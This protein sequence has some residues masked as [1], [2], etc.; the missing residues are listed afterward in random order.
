MRFSDGIWKAKEGVHISSAEEVGKISTSNQG[1]VEHW[2]PFLLKNAQNIRLLASSESCFVRA[3]CHTKALVNPADVMGQVTLTINMSSPMDGVIGV[4]VHHFLGIPALKS[5]RPELF[6]GSQPATR[7]F[8]TPALVSL[9]VRDDRI[10][11]AC[12]TTKNNDLV[13]RLDCRPNSFRLDFERPG[14]GKLTSIGQEALQTVLVERARN[15]ALEILHAVTTGS[16]P[17]FRPPQH[18]R[19]R[20]MSAALNLAVGEKVYGLGERFG[21]L[22][23]NGQSVELTNGDGGTSTAIGENNK[24]SHHRSGNDE[25][26]PSIQECPFLYHEPRLWSLF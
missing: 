25:C 10:E 1:D 19:K 20:Y 16:D 24:S 12:L 8:I 23:R 22:M 15:D 26:S 21:P 14:K 6:P 17:Y 4:E 13:A 7:A 2:H 3:V 5:A 18:S 9:T 11:E